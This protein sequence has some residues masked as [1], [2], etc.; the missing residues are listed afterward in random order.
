MFLSAVKNLRRVVA[1]L[2]FTLAITMTTA[3]M[4][5]FLDE[6]SERVADSP[7]QA[8][9]VLFESLQEG[10]VYFNVDFVDWRGNPETIAIRFYSNDAEQEFMLS[11][12]FADRF[13]NIDFE[14]FLNEERF[15]AGSSVFGD[16]VLGARFATIGEDT[17]AFISSMYEQ[18]FLPVMPT[19]LLPQEVMEVLSFVEEL[20]ANGVEEITPLDLITFALPFARHL[21]INTAE[22]VV[23]GVD[24]QR[25]SITAH[26]DVVYDLYFGLVELALGDNQMF[27]ELFAAMQEDMPFQ[28]G[29][30]TV[31]AYISDAGRLLQGSFAF[32]G[33]LVTTNWRGEVF[34]DPFFISMVANFGADALDTWVLDLELEDNWGPVAGRVEWV[35][36][37]PTDYS[38]QHTLSFI[39]VRDIGGSQIL[40]NDDFLDYIEE[41]YPE[42]YMEVLANFFAGDIEVLIDQLEAKF[43]VWVAE[44]PSEDSG[45]HLT[46]GLVWNRNNNELELFYEEVSRNWNSSDSI[47]GVFT[48]DATSFALEFNEPDLALLIGAEVG[49]ALP[50]TD[51]VNL[52]QWAEVEFVRDMVI[53]MLTFFPIITSANVTVEI[54]DTVVELQ[55][56]VVEVV[57]ELPAVEVVET[58]PAIE[59]PVEVEAPQ[60]TATVVNC[61]YLYLRVGAGV[62]YRAFNHLVVGDVVVV[63]ATRGNWVQVQTHRGT[64]W[65][66]GHFLDIH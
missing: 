27:G 57:E 1:L 23:N 66:Y 33:N 7:L 38:V 35:V 13:T 28:D 5:N 18:G 17:L 6:L 53:D 64:G 61:R 43:E 50:T 3:A 31:A 46:F 65:V 62:D 34:V 8:F 19:N 56:V 51:F 16:Y 15:A 11:F 60:N 41:S 58:L 55:P 59:V 10:V 37:E 2:C 21:D 45:D 54:I 9:E 44:N 32:D 4:P 26:I 25:T 24:A 22:A 20:F 12:D 42:F 30:I 29:Y 63:L 40:W 47:T 14:A 48:M 39:E 49:V 36:S 52:D